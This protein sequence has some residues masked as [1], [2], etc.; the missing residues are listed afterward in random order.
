MA[1]DL[2]EAYA[3]GAR[4]PERWTA[5][6]SPAELNAAPIPGKWSVQQCVLHVLDSDLIASHRMKRII[7]EDNPLLI[8][9]DETRFVAS[10]H[11]DQMDVRLGCELFALN[12]EQTTAILRRL[13]ETAFERTGIHNQN[14]KVT[15]SQ[16]IAGY[17]RHLAH[18]REFVVE[19]RRALGKPM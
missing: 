8:A 4:E 2:I 18:H 13:P 5:G 14:G 9:Y 7:A 16:V 1:R 15:L 3:A 19:K 11:Y 12:R 17:V 10:L 6:L